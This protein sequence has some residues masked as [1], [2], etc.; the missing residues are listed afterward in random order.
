LQLIAA[1]LPK[2]QLLFE[3]VE[4]ERRTE[5]GRLRAMIDEVG[6]RAAARQLATDPSN[7]RR[8]VR[9]ALLP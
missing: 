2:T 4:S 8:N 3:R 6:L 7:L 1:R 9:R 5:I